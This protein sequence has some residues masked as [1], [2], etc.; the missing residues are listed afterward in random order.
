MRVVIESRKMSWTG[1][2]KRMGK[3]R[4]ATVFQGFGGET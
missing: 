2:L 3:M 1:H 4:D